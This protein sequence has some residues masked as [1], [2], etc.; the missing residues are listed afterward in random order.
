[1]LPFFETKFELNID[2]LIDGLARKKLKKIKGDTMQ[3]MPIQTSL[4]HH[5]VDPS[6]LLLGQKLLNQ[7]SFQ[8]IMDNTFQI[9]YMFQ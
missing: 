5:I 3:S 4:R 8:S 9:K 2:A 6:N 7:L 1:M